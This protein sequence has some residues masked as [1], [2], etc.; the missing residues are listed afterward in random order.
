MTGMTQDMY[1]SMLDGLL[2]AA[3]AAAEEMGIELRP[4]FIMI[5]SE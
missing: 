2:A 5:D 1:T 3:A 4:K